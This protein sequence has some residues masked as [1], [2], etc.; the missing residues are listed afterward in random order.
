MLC[1]VEHIR[2][3]GEKYSVSRILLKKLIWPLLRRLTGGRKSS[4]S[5][6][7]PDLNLEYS[8]AQKKRKFQDCEAD[9]SGESEYFRKRRDDWDDEEDRRNS[10]KTKKPAP[11][12]LS[13]IQ[14][15]NFRIRL[16]YQLNV[17]KR[18]N[19]KPS[20]LYSLPCELS[21]LERCRPVTR[22][23]G[24]HHFVVERSKPIAIHARRIRDVEFGN[25]VVKLREDK[26]KSGSWSDNEDIFA[27]D[28]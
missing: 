27:L 11:P 23:M 20:Y 4:R 25:F 22:L 10:H 28:I 16:Y 13:N 17:V 18:A 26:T 6:S 14:S 3:G 24:K 12:N 7:H 1:A 5:K 2:V 15:S 19:K 9:D 21:N 8:Y